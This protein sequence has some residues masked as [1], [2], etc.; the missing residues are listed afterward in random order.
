MDQEQAERAA[1]LEAQRM[2]NHPFVGDGRHCES[3]GDES[4][5]GSEQTG[6]ITMRVGCGYPREAHPIP[7]WHRIPEPPC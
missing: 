5:S 4:R 3:M 1:R 7:D 6:Y 2:R